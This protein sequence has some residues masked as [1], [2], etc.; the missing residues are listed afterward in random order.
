MY[1]HHLNIKF[2][3]ANSSILNVGIYLLFLGIKFNS[4]VKLKY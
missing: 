1:K 4:S 2:F 3:Y